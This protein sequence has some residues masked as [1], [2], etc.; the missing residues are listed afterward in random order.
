MALFCLSFAAAGDRQPYLTNN[1]VDDGYSNSQ[2]YGTTGTSIT[3]KADFV[4]KNFWINGYNGVWT[5]DHDDGSQYWNDT[6]NLMVWGGCKNYLGHSK[7]CD[8]NI[9]VFP[10]DYAHGIQRGQNP[11]QTDDSSNFGNQ[12]HDNN[13][14]FTSDGDFYSMGG[15]TSCGAGGGHGPAG[16]VFQT[17]NNTL[18]APKGLWGQQ[19]NPPAKD[20]N[21]K[22]AGCPTFAAWQAEGQDTGSTL[23][24]LPGTAAIVAMGKAVLDM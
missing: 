1:G 14:C 13:H 15:W 6:A 18:Y 16:H 11:C 24:D 20:K 4:T 23:K 2:K 22:P 9:I 12:Y 5:I 17:F 21:G 3:K 8:H 7:S 19:K 10:G